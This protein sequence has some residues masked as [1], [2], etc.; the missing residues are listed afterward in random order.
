MNNSH[1]C[2]Y[3]HGN[4]EL[5]PI[6]NN[7]ITI[8]NKSLNIKE[9]IIISNK[10]SKTL[11]GILDV[12]DKHYIYIQNKIKNYDN[13]YNRYNVLNEENIILKKEIKILKKRK[14]LSD[15][16][17]NKIYDSGKKLL[18]N[19]TWR[20]YYNYGR[21]LINDQF[22]DFKNK[23]NESK[24]EKSYISKMK[25]RSLRIYKFIEK[26]K[27]KDICNIS[28]TLRSIFHKSNHDFNM[29]LINL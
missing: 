22:D 18:Q 5:Y 14:D 2:L 6:K 7:K 28:Y 20:K 3:A 10:S 17:V 4:E 26:I 29:F 25:N 13:L 16:N 1:L 23:I 8:I 12:V 19:N 9:D 24:K 21:L 27:L 11:N 15:I